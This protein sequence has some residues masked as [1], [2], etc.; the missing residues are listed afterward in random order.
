VWLT[1]D[2]RRL[3]VVILGDVRGRFVRATLV[4]AKVGRQKVR[5]TA[6]R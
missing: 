3:P 2:D 5:R 4:E 1:I 6:S